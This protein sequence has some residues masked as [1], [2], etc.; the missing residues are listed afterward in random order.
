MDYLRGISGKSRI[1]RIPNDVNR[2]E[3]SPR[4]WVIS[5]GWYRINVVSEAKYVCK[6]RRMWRK[7]AHGS[8]MKIK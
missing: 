6:D 2:N 4:C 7:V 5:R 3:C 8:V 1:D